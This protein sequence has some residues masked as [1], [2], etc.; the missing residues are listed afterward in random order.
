MKPGRQQLLLF[1][2]KGAERV[3]P[4]GVREVRLW[5]LPKQMAA[6]TDLLS[7]VLSA[8][9]L[10]S[11]SSERGKW[12]TWRPRKARRS[13][14]T[15]GIGPTWPIPAIVYCFETLAGAFHQDQTRWTVIICEQQDIPRHVQD[16]RLSDDIKRVTLSGHQPLVQTET[17]HDKGN[18]EVTHTFTSVYPF[19]LSP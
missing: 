17:V 12:A 9:E 11:G 14:Q 3:F 16:V 6:E 10:C 8:L 13:L 5:L 2:R 1:R 18:Q 4:P 19:K 7:S 15:I